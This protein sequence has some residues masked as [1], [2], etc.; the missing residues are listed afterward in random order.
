MES[1]ETSEMEV[2]WA[3]QLQEK[4]TIINKANKP[5]KLI[6]VG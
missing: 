4:R 3:Q 5:K 1:A 6:F 2:G